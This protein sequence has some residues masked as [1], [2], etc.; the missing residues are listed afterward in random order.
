[1][2]THRYPPPERVGCNRKIQKYSRLSSSSLTLSFIHTLKHTHARTQ[3]H[4]LTLQ[5]MSTLALYWM[6]TQSLSVFSW[7]LP[8]SLSL[9]ISLTH[10]LSLSN[11]RTLSQA[12][13]HT[14]ALSLHLALPDLRELAVSWSLALRTE[15]VSPRFRWSEKNWKRAILLHLSC[16]VDQLVLTDSTLPKCSKASIVDWATISDSSK[17][18]SKV[19][20]AKSLTRDVKTVARP[21]WDSS[22]SS[23]DFKGPR[24]KSDDSALWQWLPLYWSNKSLSA[25]GWTERVI[26][27]SW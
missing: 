18:F 5:I 20:E 10:P 11:T 1:M 25:A 26:H 9:M 21:I 3:A 2:L 14:L 24:Q 22:S 15:T 23:S 7:P 12:H 4:T 17:E 13:A 6:N 8:L 19:S 27:I 16:F